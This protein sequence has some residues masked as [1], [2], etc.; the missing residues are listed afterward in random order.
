[1]FKLLNVDLVFLQDETEH[2]HWSGVLP[3]HFVLA[4]ILLNLPATETVKKTLKSPIK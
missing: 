2:E 1:M 3:R 4:S